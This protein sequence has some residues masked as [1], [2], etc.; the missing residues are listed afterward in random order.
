V[1]KD[2]I[3]DIESDNNATQDRFINFMSG[4]EKAFSPKVIRQLTMNMKNFVTNTKSS[5]QSPVTQLNQDIVTQQQKYIQYLTRANVISLYKTGAVGTTGTDGLQ[6]KNGNI[7]IYDI[8]G[9]TNVYSTSEAADTFIE[10]QNDIKKIGYSI[11]SFY[12]LIVKKS[13]FKYESSEYNGNALYGVSSEGTTYDKDLKSK[14]F[15]PFSKDDIFQVL[16]F[17][18][19]YMI[20]SSEILDDKKYQTFKNAIIGDIIKNTDM[21]GSGNPDV[22]TQFDAYWIGIAKPAFAKENAITTAFFD[23]LEKG[24]LKNYIN[25][26]PFGSKDRLF[27]FEKSTSPTASQTTMINGLGRVLANTDKNTWNNNDGQALVYVSKLKLN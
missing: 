11:S 19:M 4:K 8:S 27:T 9:T 26:T 20:L 23:S 17:K 13:T 18:R 21:I 7:I 22:G 1:F 16:S 14:V 24:E 25:Y 10:I 12:D 6:E 2:Y 3:A 5:Y 15:E